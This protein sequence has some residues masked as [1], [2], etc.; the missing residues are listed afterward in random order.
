MKGK[1]V[2][3][4]KATRKGGQGKAAQKREKGKEAAHEGPLVNAAQQGRRQNS[5]P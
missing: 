3:P 1:R 2:L 4:D 5:R